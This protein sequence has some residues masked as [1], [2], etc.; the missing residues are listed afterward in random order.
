M[1]GT[2]TITTTVLMTVAQNK[3]R[4]RLTRPIRRR[5]N[6]VIAATVNSLDMEL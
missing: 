2:M 1:T 5:G 3:V 4:R 6:T